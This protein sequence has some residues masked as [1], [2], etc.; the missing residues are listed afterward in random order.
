MASFVRRHKIISALLAVLAALI[1]LLILVVIFAEPI[2]R[3]LTQSKGSEQL[4]RPLVIDGAFDIDW[5]WG[6]T[7]VHAEKIRLG[8]APGYPEPDM[9]VVAQLDVGI[10]PLKLLTGRLE[11]G[12]IL[13]KQPFVV[14]DRKSLTDYNWNFP[15]LSD[16]N[17]A[18]EA[19]EP[20]DRHDFPLIRSLK[21]QQG[22]FIFR[23]AVKDMN[24]DLALDTAVGMGG[25][26]QGK[27]DKDG[28]DATVDDKHPL[29][30]TGKGS[31]QRQ[32]FVMEAKGGAIQYL[33]DS[34]EPYPLEFKLT[35]GDTRVDMAGAFKDP[36]R[37]SGIDANLKITGHTLSD[38]F[39]LT[40]IPLPPTPPY[41]LTGRLTKTGSIWGYERFE[42]K[43]GGSDL[44]GSLSYDIGGKR[45]FLRADLLSHV[46]DSADLGGFI[47]LAPGGENAAPEQKKEAAEKKASPKLIPDVPL[48]LERLRATD[49]DVTLRAEK[50]SAPNLP[51]KGMEVRFDL[52]NGFLKLDPLKLV[53]ADGTLDGNIAV[54]AQKDVPPM[55]VDLNIRKL[56]LAQFFANTRFAN[57]TEGV[58][59]GRVQLAGSGVSLADVLAGS[60]GQITMIM[61]SGKISRLLIEAADI[62]IAQAL[63][64]FLGKDKATHIRCAVVDFDVRNGQLDSKVLVLDTDDSLMV[65]NLGMDFKN[66]RLDGRLDAKPKDSSIFAA[67]IPITIR[68]PLK[69]PQVGLEGKKLSRKTVTVAALAAV[70]NPL[71]GLLPFIE[72]GDAQDADCRALIAEAREPDPAPKP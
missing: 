69:S 21:I 50:I 14:L 25:K 31:L 35:M 46:L 72:R 17:A 57:T 45:G 11:F 10:K 54:D 71:A 68:G 27:S 7:K 4:G 56:S 40:A 22:R 26:A 67:Q 12:D 53:L 66:E 49:L 61:T 9:L 65:G 6:Y 1:F 51:F 32:P 20:D 8:N 36:V 70:L 47:G 19:L 42:G 5:H 62:D 15:A 38:L 33:R 63:P 2:I 55:T 18:E 37:L 48:K 30:V 41:T 44:S 60:N 58:F 3:S 29:R 39:Y 24:L 64:L 59:G 34:N 28:N 43:V 13:I 16:A 52:R 23:D